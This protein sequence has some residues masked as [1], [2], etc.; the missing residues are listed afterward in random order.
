MKGRFVIASL[1]P[2]RA[3]LSN[4]LLDPDTH[5]QS[6]DVKAWGPR[7]AEQLNKR[8]SCCSPNSP[9]FN[10]T[11]NKTVLYW[12]SS[13]PVGLKP[14]KLTV[15]IYSTQNMTPKDSPDSLTFF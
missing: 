5:T 15:D 6:V 9:P 10:T 12:S 11:E 7:L 2:P 14:L 4:Q 1:H 8:P 3:S 13:A